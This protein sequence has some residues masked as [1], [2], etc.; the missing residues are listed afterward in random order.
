MKNDDDINSMPNHFDHFHSKGNLY[1][2]PNLIIVQQ[3]GKVHDQ[4]I[5]VRKNA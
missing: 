1:K 5:A 2:F 3:D 4:K